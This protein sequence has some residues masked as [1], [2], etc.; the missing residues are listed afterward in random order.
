VPPRALDH[1][2]ASPL[3]DQRKPARPPLIKRQTSLLRRARA[4]VD[5]E[6]RQA[7]LY[8]AIG[9]LKV[10]LAWLKVHLKSY[11]QIPSPRLKRWERGP[12]LPSPLTWTPY[13]R[14]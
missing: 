1:V 6:A 12:P 11:E 5:T 10:E 4:Q 13:R 3:V 9:R 2:E 14:S 8:E 7:Q